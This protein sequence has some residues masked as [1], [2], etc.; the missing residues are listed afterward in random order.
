M[1][2]AFLFS[3]A[4]FIVLL[5]PCIVHADLG[6]KPTMK[7][8]LTYQTSAT[9]TLLSGKLYECGEDKNCVAMEP[10]QNAGPAHFACDNNGCDSIS[11]GYSTYQKLVFTFSDKTR[12]SQIFKNTDFNSSYN[13]T[14]TDNSLII[15]K[16]SGSNPRSVL[17]YIITL[18]SFVLSLIITLIIELL[19]SSIYLFASRKPKKILLHVILANLISLPV[20]WL[21]VYIKTPAIITVTEKLLFAEILVVIFEALFIHRLNKN[22]LTLKQAFWLS[23]VMN[24]ASF[25]LGQYIIIFLAT[26]Q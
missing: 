14:V 24:L 16:I 21:L 20:V 2:K 22:S 17:N 18:I 8:R 19:V 25:F 9:T 10:F 13:V 11:Y 23:I 26:S 1:K 12:E 3:C 6:P 4:F 15:K 7:F 5:S